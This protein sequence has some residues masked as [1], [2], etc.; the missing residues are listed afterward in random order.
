M[1]LLIEDYESRKYSLRAASPNEILREL[2]RA[3][4]LRQKDLVAVF[5]S[6]GIASEVVHSRRNISRTQAK[7]LAQIFHVSPALFL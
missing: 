4:G 6:K 1:L 7:R 3:R 2:M 5:G